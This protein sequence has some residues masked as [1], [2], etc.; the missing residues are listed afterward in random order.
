MNILSFGSLA[1]GYA[2]TLS[3]ATVS[4][5]VSGTWIFHA[6]QRITPT[7]PVTDV[8]S[9]IDNP[10]DLRLRGRLI[11]SKGTWNA[12]GFVNFV[13]SYRNTAVIPAEPVSSWKRTVRKHHGK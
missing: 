4:T 8:V 12:A 1:F 9:T 5:G 6:R 13:D 3:G 11:V 2:A 10:A 7:A